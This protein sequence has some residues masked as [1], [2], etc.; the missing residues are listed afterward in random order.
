M[1][2]VFNQLVF[3][4]LGIIDKRIDIMRICICC[5]CTCNSSIVLRCVLVIPLKELKCCRTTDGCIDSVIIGLKGYLA[6]TVAVN[7]QLSGIF[8]AFDSSNGSSC[9]LVNSNA[10]CHR[11]IQLR[12]EFFKALRIR[13][14]FSTITI[15]RLSFTI[16]LS[17]GKSNIVCA[18]FSFGLTIDVFCSNAGSN[19]GIGS[20]QVGLFVIGQGTIQQLTHLVSC[21]TVIF[22]LVTIVLI[23]IQNTGKCVIITVADSHSS[24]H[25]ILLH[26][27]H[28]CCNINDIFK[29]LGA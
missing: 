29:I 26:S 11:K 13:Q 3:A 16:S 2:L 12:K 25:R 23:V 1:R 17:A 15:L 6:I 14:T 10:A 22:V 20:T 21:T 24:A 5:N 4:Q 19:I 18:T 8:I 9:T 7:I 27:D 28:I